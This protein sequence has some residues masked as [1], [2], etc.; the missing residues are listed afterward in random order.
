MRASPF[1]N[2][3]I[4][5]RRSSEISIFWDPK[6]RGSVSARRS[7]E[8]RSS[9]V[10]S[11]NTNTLHRDRS[12][13]LISKEGFSVVAPIK[14]MLP[15]STKGRKASCC[16]LLKRWISSTN[17]MVRVPNRRLFSASCMTALISL[18][19]LVTAEKSMK[20]DLVR[21]AMILA[22]V[23]FPTPGGPQKIME[24]IRS[25]SMRRRRTF[26][27]PRRWVC[28]TYSSSVSGR[29]RAARG[30]GISRS[31][32]VICSMANPP[33]LEMPSSYSIIRRREKCK[34][35]LDAVLMPKC[36]KL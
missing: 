18:I 28:P 9:T 10:S 2:R 35:R 33:C 29:S 27:G 19:P 25:L 5:S 26:P 15:F 21:W 23:V 1:A 20:L 32:S 34:W 30:C 24:E 22:R 6:P 11:F 14:I 4:I 8:S 31:K 12:A 16:A 3:A 36:G 7:R 17:T 13:P